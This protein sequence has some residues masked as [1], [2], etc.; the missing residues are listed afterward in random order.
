MRSYRL[1]AH[2]DEGFDQF[3]GLPQRLVREIEDRNVEPSACVL[4]AQST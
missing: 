3:N 2:R 1:A 4:D